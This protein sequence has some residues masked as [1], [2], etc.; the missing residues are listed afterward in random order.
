MYRFVIAA[1]PCVALGAAAIWTVSAKADGTPNNA[2]REGA[3]GAESPAAEEPLL[4]P[5]L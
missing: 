2:M 1:L 3:A 5:A 4:V